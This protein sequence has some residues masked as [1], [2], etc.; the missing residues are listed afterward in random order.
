[1]FRSAE[2]QKKALRERFSNGFGAETVKLGSLILLTPIARKLRCFYLIIYEAWGALGAGVRRFGI[3]VRCFGAG[4]R[5][6]G[7][8]FRRFNY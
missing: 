3:G 2:L 4:V 7:I 8:G 6:F 1:M 5:R